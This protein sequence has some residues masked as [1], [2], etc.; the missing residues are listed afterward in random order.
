VKISVEPVRGFTFDPETGLDDSA[1]TVR[2]EWQMAPGAKKGHANIAMESSRP[3]DMLRAAA[4]FFDDAD[5]PE[6]V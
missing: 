2:V 4:A 3:Q 6:A 5:A 1:A